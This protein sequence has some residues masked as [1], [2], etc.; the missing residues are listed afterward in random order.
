M[1]ERKILAI[2]GDLAKLAEFQ[3]VSFDD[4]AKD[5][6]KHKSVERVIEVIL[7]EA[8]DINQHLIVKSGQ[9]KLPFDFKQS[10]LMLVDLGV[11]PKEF[12]E[13]IATSVGLRNILVHQ[14]RE[15]DER[16]FYASIKE[17]LTQYTEYCRYIT[18]YLGR[19]TTA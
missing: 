5:Y 19:V 3:D 17:C 16:V 10:Y 13:T 14:Y 1:V 7:N 6:W 9:G 18:T 12:A 2:Q 8:I 15:L 4:I 11:Y